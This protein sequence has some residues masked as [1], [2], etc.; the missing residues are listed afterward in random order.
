MARAFVGAGTARSKRLKWRAVF[1]EKMRTDSV[2][3]RNETWIILKVFVQENVES[4][5]HPL[6]DINSLRPAFANTVMR[7]YFMHQIDAW[8]AFLND[9]FDDKV[10]IRTL[11]GCEMNFNMVKPSS[12]GLYGMK[13]EQSPWHENWS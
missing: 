11:P 13:Q 10:F 1:K 3:S 5:C 8:M 2:S 9:D 7:H 12:C 6:A 4:S